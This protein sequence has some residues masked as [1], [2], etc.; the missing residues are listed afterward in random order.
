MRK[1]KRKR[2]AVFV[3]TSTRQN[4]D[5][6][7]ALTGTKTTQY[8]YHKPYVQHYPNKHED[9]IVKSS[10]VSAAAGGA[11]LV[12]PYLP[13]WSL[14]FWHPAISEPGIVVE[15]QIKPFSIGELHVSGLC[16]TCFR[17]SSHEPS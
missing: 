3:K 16:Y 11:S 7:T 13:F 15:G 12:V 17:L 4:D 1:P 8:T 2:A 14:H 5:L 9:K 10:K 6:S